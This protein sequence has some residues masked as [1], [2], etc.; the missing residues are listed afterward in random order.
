MSIVDQ[1]N[2]NDPKKSKKKFNLKNIEIL[3]KEI[4]RLSY[5]E[6][7]DALESI[8]VEVQ[9][10]NISLDKIKNNYIKGNMLLKHCEELL[11]VV[12]QEINDINLEN[13]DID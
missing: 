4:K 11:Q 6:S 2:A 13:L 1:S 9:D 8:L 7:I 3:G 5:E 10:E 12:E